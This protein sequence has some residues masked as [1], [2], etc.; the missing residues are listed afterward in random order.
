MI[1]ERQLHKNGRIIGGQ[2]ARAG[3]LPFAAAIYITTSDGSYFCGG[4][5]IS[6]QWILTAGQCVNSA[7]LL[8]IHLGATNLV[9]DDPNRIVV[10]T[11]D[12]VIHPDFN[13]E[14]LDNDI[15]LIKLRLPIEF[16]GY[17]KP[18]DYLATHTLP[19]GDRSV[20]I[21]WGH[22]S[23]EAAEFSNQLQWA[24]VISISNDQCKIY[25][26]NQIT[27]TMV[28]IDGIYYNEGTCMGDS[29]GPLIQYVRQYRYHAGVASFYSA[30]GC[31][32][33]D[34]SGYT[35]TYPYVEWIKNI[36]GI[37]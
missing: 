6:D 24:N 26:G 8:T 16:T 31:E 2:E 17:I 32:T 10:A 13:P 19:V 28:C 20:S 9:G 33:T 25:Y 34:P 30:N 11:S 21:G 37:I 7:I 5:L 29:G 22:T 4:T 36:T 12:Y 18:I 15:A 35:R 14:T 1:T 3:Q 27:E 23:D